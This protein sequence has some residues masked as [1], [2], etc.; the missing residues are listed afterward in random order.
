MFLAIAAA[1]PL[2]L[3]AGFAPLGLKLAGAALPVGFLVPGILYGLFAV[4]FTAMARHI[5]GGG[6]FY[7]YIAQG[8]G[9]AVGVGAAL[10]GYV[11][12]LGCQIG[13]VAACGVF[14]SS[15]LSG[16]FGLSVPVFVCALVTSA[17]V[18]VLGY[19]SVN[20]GAWVLGVLLSLELGILAVFCTS[21]LIRGGREGLSLN[22]FSP[23]AFLTSG[24]ASVFVLTFVA[25]VGF[26]QTTMYGEDVVD[27]RRTVPRAT[28]ATI[29]LL[30]FVYTFCTWVIVQALGPSRLSGFHG[31]GASR[32]VF[33]LNSEFV[34]TTM[35]AVMQLLLVTSLFGGCLA[36][37]NA[38]SR[39]LLALGQA[40]ILPKVLEK[41][42]AT[43]GT[44]SIAGI[45]QAVLVSAL[46]GAFAMTPADPYMQVVPWACSPTIVAVLVL[47]VLV[48]I[49]VIRFFS[50]CTYR[51]GIWHRLIAP[52]LA[53]VG[54]AGVLLYVLVNLSYATGLSAAQNLMLLA[55]LPAVFVAGLLRGQWLRNHV[56][57]ESDSGAQQLL[58]GDSL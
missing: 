13:F 39:Y 30:T 26:E 31:S 10:L 50:R 48:S 4:G 20:V 15:A 6:A 7:A 42:S 41:T 24:I 34:G 43:T 23:S 56:A 19:R 29:G 45:T 16:L 2:S 18:A 35:T 53:A 57:P 38:C 33:D 8:F 37:H 47:Q 9:D 44:P 11:G 5:P 21:V 1:A 46:I 58:K 27:S 28:Y 49:A 25:F 55:P 17:L 22:S 36:M 40:R 12:Y 52:T 14:M 51:E 3:I 32:L 54:L